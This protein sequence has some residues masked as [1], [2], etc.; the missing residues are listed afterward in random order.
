MAHRQT[1]FGLTQIWARGEKLPRLSRRAF[2]GHVLRR[3]FE[4]VRYSPL[5]SLVTVA[6]IA[7]CFSLFSSFLLVVENVRDALKG[8][9]GELLLSI[10][11]REKAP[12]ERVELLIESLRALPQVEAVE[13]RSKADALASFRQML[14]QHA[15]VLDGLDSDNPL[16]ASLEVRMKSDTSLDFFR[17]LALEQEQSAIV[18]QVHYSEIILEQLSALL[19]LFR[20]GG[21][22][23]MMFMF[24]MTGLIV[25]NTIRLALYSHRVEIDIMRLVGATPWFIRGPFLLEGALQGLLG[26]AISILFVFLFFRL[27]QRVLTEVGLVGNLVSQVSFLSPL[28]I[29]LVATSA[30]LVGAIGSFVAVRG[31]SEEHG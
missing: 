20:L 31:L 19:R 29:G 23:A 12:I 22:L 9:Q 16:P 14:G 7:L 26:G 8:S 1:Q 11:L 3:S 18:E 15:I 13:L 21:G 17:R 6:T 30:V 27:S 28:A 2:C 25:A 4:G 24:L 10:Y 5:T